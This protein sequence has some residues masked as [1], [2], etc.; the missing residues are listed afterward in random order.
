MFPADRALVVSGE[1]PKD[2]TCHLTLWDAKGMEEYDKSEVNG[3][4][5]TSFIV[6]PFRVDYTVKAVCNKIITAI[7]KISSNDAANHERPF[8]LGNIAP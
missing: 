7:Y 4:F 2:S 3:K 8:N 6:P 5:Q 1:A